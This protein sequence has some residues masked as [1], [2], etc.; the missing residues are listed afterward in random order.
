MPVPPF[1]LRLR[2]KVG[3]DRLWL[4][5][6]SGVVLD[7]DNRV[8][9]TQRG[10]DLRWSVVS[11][12]LEPGEQPAVAIEREI[13]EET[14]VVALVER[15]TSIVSEPEITTLPNGDQCQYLDLAFRCRYVAG[16]A[17]AADDENLEVVWFDLGR[18]PDLRS[19]D[20]DRIAW[21]LRPDL[22]PVMIQPR[23]LEPG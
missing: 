18:L 8:L 13:L 16:S 12:I 23:T 21:A 6:V 11:G 15:L 19:Q 20:R 4:T 17:R 7:A 10:D 14:A 9:L 5:G 3:H 22:Q 2:E 1:V